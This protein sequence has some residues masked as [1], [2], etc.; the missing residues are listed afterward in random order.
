MSS[1]SGGD[2]RAGKLPN[3]IKSHLNLNRGSDS[4]LITVT[5]KKKV[6]KSQIDSSNP[7]SLNLQH[8]INNPPI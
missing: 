7:T 2:S 5:N 8:I 1:S 4:G 3:K 6:S